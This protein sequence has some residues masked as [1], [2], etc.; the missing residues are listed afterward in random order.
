MADAR[1]ERA[2][3]NAHAAGDV[4]AAR[5]IAQA[6]KESSAPPP[7]SDELSALTE[8]PSGPSRSSPL[9][10]QALRQ[11]GLTARYGLEGIAGVPQIL[12]MALEAGG[13]GIK[14]AGTNVGTTISDFAGLPKPQGDFE[15]VVGGASRAMAGGAPF[16]KAGSVLANSL[17]ASKGVQAAGRT[18]AQ[19]PVAQTTLGGV[20][21]GSV[22]LARQAGVGPWGQLAIGLAAPVAAGGVA[23]T[24]AKAGKTLG[25]VV[26][27]LV[28]EDAARAGAARLA[29]TIAGPRGEQIAGAFTEAG[30]GTS[31]G[32][33]ATNLGNAEIAALQADVNRATPTTA[34]SISEKQVADLDAAKVALD[35]ATTPLRD[36]ALSAANAGGGVRAAPIMAHI[37]RILGTAGSGRASDVIAGTL[38]DIRAKMAK[39]ASANGRVDAKDA[40][41][42]RKTIG[43]TIAKHSKDNAEWDAKRSAGL[44]RDLQ[45]AIDAEIES[46]IA[47]ANPKNA[48]AWGKYLESYST[49]AQRIG[50]ARDALEAEPKL[51]AQGAASVARTLGKPEIPL[52]GFNA[53]NRTWSAINA[54]RRYTQ[55]IG[56]EKV[57]GTLAQ[58]MAPKEMGGD[59]TTLGRLMNEQRTAP[60][61]IFGNMR[62]PA[63]PTR[64]ELGYETIPL[65]PQ[66]EPPV[67]PLRPSPLPRI[68]E[69]A[70][71]I[72]GPLNEPSGPLPVMSED[73]LPHGAGGAIETPAVRTPLPEIP[74]AEVA[75]MYPTEAS[76][77]SDALRALIDENGSPL[78]TAPRTM[79]PQTLETP[80]AR[81]L[82]K[83][84]GAITPTIDARA[85]RAAA[86]NPLE[87]N[88]MMGL[89]DENL[90]APTP[91][92]PQTTVA[93]D[94]ITGRRTTETTVGREQSD[95]GTMAE[96]MPT[97]DITLQ[98]GLTP[99]ALT[100]E[101]ANLK[102]LYPAQSGMYRNQTL[103]RIAEIEQQIATLG[104]NR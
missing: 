54:L 46:S 48:G 81:Q 58:M 97:E 92:G 23:A 17:N 1:M 50:A 77:K 13:H 18:L 67:A 84:P 55:G 83:V 101:L 10:K 73:I 64:A 19:N 27:P 65:G 52:S 41:D 32:Q 88:P 30:P 63:P 36:T 24:A 29:N 94:P 12:G 91:Y 82:R 4:A 89:V 2:L 16:I 90:G 68:E 57:E 69:P 42:I 9:L 28:S 37:S 85:S 44:E 35:E 6:I 53:L 14:G 5:R 86:A 78:P 56:G 95:Y 66:V 31:G 79:E 76:V 40:Y 96:R 22:E 100:D 20:S 93:R 7:S 70:P 43:S 61:S 26:G 62:S 21:G 71:V 45:R 104:G 98:P 60:Q 74:T 72:M 59:L 39:F 80:E 47:A 99:V 15:E 102:S 3:R 34:R 75:P 38:N 11:I 103:A 87:P 49:E 25:H 8:A 51:A 33:V